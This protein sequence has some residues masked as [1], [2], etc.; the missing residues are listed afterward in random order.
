MSAWVVMP[1]AAASASN[2]NVHEY[3]PTPLSGSEVELGLADAIAL[4]LRRNTQLQSA[5][6]DRV[7]DQLNLAVAEAQFRPRGTIVLGAQQNRAPGDDA[8][9]QRSSTLSPSLDTELPTGGRIG[10]SW[11]LDQDHGLDEPAIQTSRS[12]QLSLDLNQPLLRGGG[13]AVGRAPLEIARLQETASALGLEET[14]VG[15]IDS[16]IAAYRALL[17]GQQRLEIAKGSL[18]RTVE[19]LE[20]NRAL[21]ERGRMASNELV[22]TE[23]RLANQRFSVSQAEDGVDQ[24]RL[25]LLRL[26]NLGRD[27]RLRLRDT[28]E[29]EALESLRVRSPSLEAATSIAR[30]NRPDYL[31]LRIAR[32]IESIGQM[33]AENEHLWRL[34]LNASLDAGATGRSARQATG[35]TLDERPGYALGLELEIPILDP[36]RPVRLLESRIRLRQSEIQF[37][38]REV[39]LELEVER[40]L[41]DLNSRWQQ[42]GLAQRSLELARESLEIERERLAVGRTTSFQVNATEQNLQQAEQSL[43]DAVIAYLNAQTALD[44]ALGTTLDSWGLSLPEAGV[45]P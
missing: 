13:L 12:S 34:D 1:T 16:V 8:E 39:E 23:S 5:Y 17:Q 28:V 44:R 42:L 7:V 6:L 45:M 14:V 26:L 20:R 2:F 21:V 43:L 27:T 15:T 25:E 36:E 4:A 19:Q 18:E 32:E 30:D 11:N 24:S 31:R 37:S 3:E 29:L 9:T 10:F 40:S 41:N 33:L 38:E 22:Q 35:S